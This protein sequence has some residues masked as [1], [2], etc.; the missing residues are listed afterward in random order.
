M[1]V[2]LVFEQTEFS[3]HVPHVPGELEPPSGAEDKKSWV[4]DLT[5]SQTERETCFYGKYTDK[6]GQGHGLSLA[7]G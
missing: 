4:E 1:D 3:I 2:P 6:R 5:K 7:N